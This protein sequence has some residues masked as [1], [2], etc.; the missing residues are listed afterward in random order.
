[1]RAKMADDHIVE[2]I[3]TRFFL[4]TCQSRRRVNESDVL[5][6]KFCADAVIGA[7]GCDLIPLTTGS[8][9][10]FYIE[11]MLPCIGD[12]D[13]M[14]H[15]ADQ[16][17][18]PEGYTPPTQLPGEF[19][20]RVLVCE[21]VNSEF[22]GY[23]YLVTAYLL[24]ECVD[25]DAYSAL[26]CTTCDVAYYGGT[27]ADCTTHGP[28]I[29]HD[30]TVQSVSLAP[31]D[32]SRLSV[33][34]AP[35]D[36]GI[37]LDDSSQSIDDVL[38]TRCLTWPPQAADW[39]TRHRIYGWP[40]S[41]T[42]DRVVSN[43]C[44][45]VRAVHRLCRQDEWMSTRQWRLS[46]S[47]AEIVLLNS[48]TRVQQIVYHMLR[49][50][51]KTELL[52]D[53]S[54]DPGEGTLSNYHI[55]TLMLWACELKPKSWWTDDLN[56]VRICVELLHTLAVWLTDAR[57][58]H[59]FI[60]NCNLF[61]QSGDS[62]YGLA[63]A[64]RLMSITRSW[65]CEWCIDSYVHKCAELCPGSVSSLLRESASR[66]PHGGLHSVVCLQNVASA[67]VQWKQDKSLK[68]AFS[69]YSTA[70]ARIMD[71]VFHYSLTLRSCLCWIHHL[72]KAEQGLRLYFTALV[73]LHVAYK[74]TQ[75]SLTDEMLDVLTTTCLQLDDVRRCLKARHSSVLSLSQAARLMKVVASNSR[76]TVQLIEIELSKAY[77]H[78]ALRCKDSGSDS[79]YCLTNVYLAVL[80]YT[81]GQY[82]MAMDH[83]V[84]VSRLQDHSQCSSHTVQGD[85]LPTIN[86]EIDNMLGLAVFYQYIRSAALNE[87][88]ERQNV[89]FFTTEL[90]AHYLHSKLLSDKKC[91]QLTEASLADEI[92]RYRNCFCNSP[93][94][95]V[96]DMILFAFANRTKCPSNDRLVMTD[97]GENSSLVLDQLDT[98]KLVELLQ[99]SAVE[100]L[101][102]SRE[103]EARDFGSLMRIVTTDFKALH[104]YKYGQYQRCLQLSTECDGLGMSGMSVFFF[105]ELIQLMDDDIVSLLGLLVL[106]NR[107]HPLRFLA[108]FQLT[109]FLYLTTQCRIK[110]RHPAIS[111][112][113]TLDNVQD[114]LSTRHDIDLDVADQL[115]LKYVEQKILRYMSVDQ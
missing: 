107:S 33:P 2:E 114:A 34:L 66:R 89:C 46:F 75:S 30:Y 48:W 29:F 39:P 5:A 93:D 15:I 59:Y 85:L 69:H 28:A 26:Q 11:P 99:Q 71:S 72:A 22:P 73:F 83:C 27:F 94:M 44:D 9:A 51:V 102:T 112:A 31:S 38:C 19:D 77:L 115:V 54:D 74:T 81:T 82:Q 50:F 92:Q 100:H 17:A 36:F 84:L 65:F 53:S 52:S 23:V 104:A 88:H 43:G 10:E 18:I 8:V 56:L 111:L 49:V 101:T 32:F 80:Y 3:I 12:V 40:D 86:D 95:F 90:F 35:S 7:K 14:C 108:V 58:K 37:R 106:V 79:I 6:W 105:P 63:I 109:L 67:I 16:L 113:T 20:S 42:V 91:R 41:A 70:Q 76:S 4:K 97:E 68:M 98:V 47:R 45:V 96:T 103:L 61:V 60:N 21:I 57:C 78:R 55:K 110:L 1:V 62:R 24:T 13:I 64:N 25:D 87:Q